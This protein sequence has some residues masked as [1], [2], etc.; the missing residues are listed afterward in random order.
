MLTNGSRSESSHILQVVSEFSI[1]S[2][3]EFDDCNLE[4]TLRAKSMPFLKSRNGRF[5]PSPVTSFLKIESLSIGHVP[6]SLGLFGMTTVTNYEPQIL[7]ILQILRQVLSASKTEADISFC[8]ADPYVW[9][10]GKLSA[11]YHTTAIAA[12]SLMLGCL[13]F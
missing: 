3:G 13:R 6:I 2:D 10:P 7:F 1:L 5:G 11:Y 4:S 12:C 8:L 9:G